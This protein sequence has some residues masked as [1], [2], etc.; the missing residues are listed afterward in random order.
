MT[1]KDILHACYCCG[2]N[3]TRPFIQIEEEEDEDGDPVDVFTPIFC[4]DCEKRITPEIVK[5]VEEYEFDELFKVLC[6]EC[7]LVMSETLDDI[8]I[9][10]RE[11]GHL[12][13]Y[14]SGDSKDIKKLSK[15]V[16]RS[17]K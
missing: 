14:A 4:I 3:Q 7:S 1:K 6:E 13:P 8:S 17:L 5:K 16:K 2:K 12:K 11:L 9:N 15:S 10:P